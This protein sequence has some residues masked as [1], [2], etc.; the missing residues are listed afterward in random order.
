LT[1]VPLSMTVAAPAMVPP[2]VTPLA[3]SGER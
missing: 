2:A 1:G 3:G